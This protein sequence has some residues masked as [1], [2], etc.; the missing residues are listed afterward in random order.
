MYFI[1]D[2]S[3]VWQFA[4][5]STWTFTSSDMSS[6]SVV[7]GEELVTFIIRLT[8]PDCDAGDDGVG[9]PGGVVFGEYVEDGVVDPGGILSVSECTR[10]GIESVELF[11]AYPASLAF[12]LRASSVNN[13][14]HVEH[15][16]GTD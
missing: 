9:D 2:L 4:M 10:E 13:S 8:S 7:R 15:L 12:W 1:T 3:P 16:T 14:L 11:D 6:L 5:P